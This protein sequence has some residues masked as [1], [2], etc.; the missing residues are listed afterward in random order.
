MTERAAA[1]RRLLGFLEVGESGGEETRG[2][3]PGD[4]AVVEGERERHRFAHLHDRFGSLERANP[5]N[6]N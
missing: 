2:F 3:A 6:L 5:I 1:G 4:R